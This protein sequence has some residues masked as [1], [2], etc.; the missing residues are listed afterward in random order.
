M[1]E[2]GVRASEAHFRE[3][4][5]GE[6]LFSSGRNACRSPSGRFP[7]VFRSFPEFPGASERTCGPPILTRQIGTARNLPPESAVVARSRPAAAGAGCRSPTPEPP[8]RPSLCREP[9]AAECRTRLLPVFVRFRPGLRVALL[10]L[11]P[12]GGSL[13]GA[14][15]PAVDAGGKERHGFE[16]VRLCLCGI[17]VSV[18]GIRVSVRR[19]GNVVRGWFHGMICL[20]AIC[21]LFFC[22]ERSALRSTAAGWRRSRP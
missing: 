7:D 6:N 18:C 8:R 4:G 10:H 21:G 13:S 16:I 3:E 17:R 14:A 15:G 9:F 12:L 11:R 2:D 1:G 20:R 19:T 5:S 22:D